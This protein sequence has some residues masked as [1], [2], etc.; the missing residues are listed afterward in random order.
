MVV[1][2]T[3]IGFSSL[4]N[5]GVLLTGIGIFLRLGAAV[6]FAIVSAYTHTDGELETIIDNTDAA[7]IPYFL[8]KTV[9]R[10]T[11]G[12]AIEE[13]Y[14]ALAGSRIG[15][16]IRVRLRVTSLTVEP[17]LVADE[18][19]T[20]WL[21]GTGGD[22]L[23]DVTSSL[24]LGEDGT[25]RAL[26]SS[27]AD[28]RAEILQSV[29]KAVSEVPVRAFAPEKMVAPERADEPD[30]SRDAG[31]RIRGL[32][33]ETLGNLQELLIEAYRD[34]RQQLSQKEPKEEVLNAAKARVIAISDLIVKVSADA[35]P[36]PVIREQTT[37]RTIDLTDVIAVIE[38]PD[39][40]HPER[41]FH[42][43]VELAGNRV[44]YELPDTPRPGVLYLQPKSFVTIITLSGKGL[45][46]VEVFRESIQYAQFGTLQLASLRARNW[47][48][49]TT[50]LEF[51][52][53]SGRLIKMTRTD[54]GV[55]DAITK[56]STSL[57][58]ALSKELSSTNPKSPMQTEID[59]LTLETNLL[60][61]RAALRQAQA[62]AAGKSK[63]SGAS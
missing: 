44:V 8:P 15:E 63:A 42:L 19:H 54:S 12:Y 50:G 59:R 18:S 13:W 21:S 40:E 61:A 20:L 23:E 52:N 24:I 6:V 4:I 48:A 16:P 11:V 38:L 2:D 37:S 55:A 27:V 43:T 22:S 36:S 46:P 35:S 14:Q 41:D 49:V 26:N 57:S 32:L 34:Y 3:Q 58:D 10:I 62:G 5:L 29:M 30:P 51:S 7:A 39:A 33:F 45:A 60:N 31:F 47:A 28:K 25:L 9:L 17:R 56:G 53:Q 1:A